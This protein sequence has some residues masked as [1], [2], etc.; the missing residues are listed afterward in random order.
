LLRTPKKDAVNILILTA[1]AATIGTYIITTTVLISKDGTTYINNAMF[2][3]NR[4]LQTIKT[5]YPGYIILIALA[6]K[7]TTLF[8]TN[9]VYTWTYTAQTLS[10]LCRILSLIPLYF[11]GKLLVGRR[12]TFWALLILIFLPYPAIFGSDVLR[13]WPHILFLSTSILCLIS[14]ARTGKW[15]FFALAGM[16]SSLGHTIRPECAQIVIYCLIW[17]LIILLSPK[18]KLTRTRALCLTFV[19]L[20]GF[21]IPAAPYIKGRGKILPYKLKKV[22]ISCPNR[23]NPSDTQSNIDNPQTTLYAGLT[24]DIIKSCGQ[25]LKGIS[26]N[27]LYYFVLPLIIGLY[28]HFRRLRRVIFTESFFILALV[29]LYAIMMILLFTKWGYI[30]RRHCMP[31]VVFTIFFVPF[32]MQMLAHWIS[33]GVLK[34]HQRNLLFLILIA[35]GLVVCFAKFARITPLRWEKEG[36]LIAANWLKEN[37]SENEIIAVPDE[38]LTFYASRKGIT[39]GRMIPQEVKYIINIVKEGDSSPV[40]KRPYEEKNSVQINKKDKTKKIVIYKLL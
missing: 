27:L 23:E 12:K 1:I 33:R 37:V 11:I 17:L 26:S 38:R 31:M 28:C 13:D 10:L 29:I 16:I 35:L 6:H 20:I 5:D 21:A 32:G 2:F 30:S 7:I 9:S 3:L 36:Y 25:L 34:G 15:W 24:P 4:P 39:I 8:F 14:G 18:P 40:F 22:L 19:L